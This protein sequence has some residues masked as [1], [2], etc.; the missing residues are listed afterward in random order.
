[1]VK[2]EDQDDKDEEDNGRGEKDVTK[3]IKE[4]PT[5]PGSAPATKLRRPRAPLQA[6]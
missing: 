3:Q 1:M 2:N 5:H 6:S 4:S